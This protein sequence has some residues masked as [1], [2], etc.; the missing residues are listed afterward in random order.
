M[1][2]KPKRLQQVL[3]LVSTIAFVGS[4]GLGA[5]S[6][7]TTNPNANIE[8]AN[9]VVEKSREEQL[10]VQIRG[11][12]TVLQREPDNQAALAGLVQL[13]LE[14]RD[15]QGAIAPLEKLVKLNP[16]QESYKALL[17][18]VKKQ[19]NRVDKSREKTIAK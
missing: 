9:K 19:A 8:P 18:E 1:A 6:L 13:R 16:N 17:T 5:V 11:Y 3:I 4:T 15:L 10:Q 14:I 2:E 7:F 12:E